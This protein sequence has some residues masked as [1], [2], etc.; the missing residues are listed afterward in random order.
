MCTLL[1]FLLPIFA[2]HHRQEGLSVWIPLKIVVGVYATIAWTFFIN[3]YSFRIQYYDVALFIASDTHFIIS[4][5]SS[6]PK[7]EDTGT[8]PNSWATPFWLEPF[9]RHLS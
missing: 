6:S 9:F 3:Y 2:N 1:A 8:I 4:I 7:Q 5:S